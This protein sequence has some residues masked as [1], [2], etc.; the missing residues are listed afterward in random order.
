MV[1]RCREFFFSNIFCFKNFPRQDVSRHLFPDEILSDKMLPDKIFPDKIFLAGF[2][3]AGGG[4]DTVHP[5]NGDDVV[6]GGLGVH[7]L[8]LNAIK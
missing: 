7:T 1:W 2:I 4:D 6:N 5:F 8:L 3:L